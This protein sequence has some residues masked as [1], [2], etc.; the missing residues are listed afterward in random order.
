MGLDS[1]YDTSYRVDWHCPAQHGCIVDSV[2]LTCA[3]SSTISDKMSSCFSLGFTTIFY[4]LA[5]VEMDWRLAVVL[6]HLNFSLCH[7][8]KMRTA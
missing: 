2:R 7:V 3:Q 8:Q 5:D 1:C 6:K 4:K